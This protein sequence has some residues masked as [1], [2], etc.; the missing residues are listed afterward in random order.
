M[1]GSVR[2]ECSVLAQGMEAGWRPLAFERD[3]RRLFLWLG[4]RGSS[5]R[6]SSDVQVVP[7]LFKL[8]C[9]QDDKGMRFSPDTE[10]VAIPREMCG[11]M[12]ENQHLPNNKG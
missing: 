9:A 2:G 3:S 6:L 10:A 12:G 4:P 8:E 11:R 5:W 1:Q 7:V